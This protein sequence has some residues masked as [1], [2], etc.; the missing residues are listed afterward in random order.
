MA[1][2][3]R[4]GVSGA[5]IRDVER[6]LEEIEEGLGRELT[7]F[8][9]VGASEIA[10]DTREFTPYDPAHRWDRKDHLPHIRDTIAGVASGTSGSVIST[11]PGAI[12]HEWG[13]TIS[14]RGV[15]ITIRQAAMAHR[16]AARD[17]P[18]LRE[19]LVAALDELI[20]SA[21]LA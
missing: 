21:G 10:A 4:L 17:F 1:D 3:L 11:H 9:E 8:F 20:A 14:P 18:Q 16:A 7:R 2:T 12:V 5:D 15:P 19:R 13:G 6:A